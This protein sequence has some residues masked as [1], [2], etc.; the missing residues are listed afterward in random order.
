MVFL[1]KP[2]AHIPQFD[3]VRGD[4]EENQVQLQ[5]DQDKCEEKHLL[6]WEFLSGDRRAS[7]IAASGCVGLSRQETCV[8]IWLSPGC[9][10]SVK[11]RE[12]LVYSIGHRPVKVNIADEQL[13]VNEMKV[14]GDLLLQIV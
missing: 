10:H 9:V 11:I 6:L 2:V 4:A 12:I 8:L 1:I 7:V 14:L 13:C 3:L 5:E